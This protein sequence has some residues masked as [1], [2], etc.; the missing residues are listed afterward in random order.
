MPTLNALQVAERLIQLG[1]APVALLP[2]DH[3]DEL[4]KPADKRG[5]TPFVKGWQTRPCPKSL[6]DMPELLPEMNVGIRTGAVVGAK[7]QVVVLDCDSEAAKWFVESCQPESKITTLTGRVDAGW[8]GQH[9]FYLR[10]ILGQR[11]P[12]QSFK[13]KWANP[14][15]DGR[16][17]LVK[18]DVKADE[19]QVV[20][21]GCRHGTGGLYEEAAPWTEQLL[22]SMPVL[23]LAALNAARADAEEQRQDTEDRHPPEKRIRRFRAYLARCEP[24]YP[25]MPPS[26]AGSHCLG[27]ARAG[28]WGFCLSAEVAAEEMFKS[29]WN[30]RCHNEDGKPWPWSM[31]DLL[32]K[33]RDASKPGTSDGDMRKQRGYLLDAVE[34]MAERRVIDLSPNVAVVCAETLSGLAAAR[35]MLGSPLVYAHG[36]HLA[37]VGDNV[38][39][40]DRHALSVAMD[41]ACVFQ[42]HKEVGKGEEKEIKVIQ[43]KPPMDISDKLLSLARWPELPQLRRVTRL[44]PVSLAGQVGSRTGY[45]V[46]SQTY[47]VGGG[48]DIPERPTKDDALRARD[49]V[50]RYVRAVKFADDGDKG[51]WLTYVLTLAT[52]TA[53]SKCP[54]FVLR[55]PEPA[56]GKTM[57][58]KVGFNLLYPDRFEP[59]DEKRPD[60]A[61]F[62]KSLYGWSQMPLVLWDNAADGRVIRNPALAAILTSGVATARELGKHRMLRADFSGTVFAYTGNNVGLSEELAMR[63]VVI[64]L[65]GR[66]EPDSSFSPE[67][68]RH[69]AAARPGATRDVY[70][71]VRAWA[72]AGCPPQPAKPHARFGDWSQVVQQLALWL[73][74]PDPLDCSAEANADEEV[75]AMLSQCLYRLFKDKFFTASELYQGVV[76]READA[77]DALGALAELSRGRKAESAVQIGKQLSGLAGKTSGPFRLSITNSRGNTA[78]Y[79]LTSVSE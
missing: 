43:T 24:S 20:A 48:V 10:P 26:G 46:S 72:L 61:D 66:P 28:V 75:F 65:R 47:Y 21:P 30:H 36:E 45:D 19:G 16:I 58:A 79:R 15:D 14:F 69:L 33:C 31:Q 3:P 18:L 35:D 12:N 71:M 64:N 68:E 42:Q 76:R 54:M 67:S 9:R 52:R 73:E 32:H 57:C 37:T 62:G 53:Y 77:M 17:Q 7:F 2:L 25:G 1:L 39:W 70:T 22:M 13:V 49:R 59:A 63:A 8:R 41:K 29:E 74:L 4:Q 56:S 60:D 40:L 55:A 23:D 34:T 50:L 27:I 44:P 5:K 6:A 38:Q 51:R 78:K 11:I